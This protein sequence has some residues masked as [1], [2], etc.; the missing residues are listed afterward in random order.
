MSVLEVL[1]CI[2]ATIV[3]SV[4]DFSHEAGSVSS[5]KI[6]KIGIHSGLKRHNREV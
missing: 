3:S 2:D 4:A 5:C 6:G 1:S